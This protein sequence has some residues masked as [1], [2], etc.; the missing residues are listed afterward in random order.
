MSKFIS[1]NSFEEG[2]QELELIS[3]LI[4]NF[5]YKNQEVYT[6]VSLNSNGDWEYHSPKYTDKQKPNLDALMASNHYKPIILIYR[7]KIISK[8]NKI[9]SPNEFRKLEGANSQTT[10][11]AVPNTNSSYST[12]TKSINL[13]IETQ[14]I[15]KRSLTK[16]LINLM[17]SYIRDNNQE[18]RKNFLKVYKTR[19][20]YLKE[21]ENGNKS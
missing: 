6:I 12:L 16:V 2:K 7:K 13:D 10:L 17:K 14:K 9:S 1:L 21:L 3:F 15:V 11:P 4:Q 8:D 18:T 20:L 19:K 5:E